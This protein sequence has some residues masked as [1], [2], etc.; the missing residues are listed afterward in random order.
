MSKLFRTVLL[1]LCLISWCLSP[2]AAQERPAGTKTPNYQMILVSTGKGWQLLRYKP[3]T[4]ETWSIQDM[5]WRKILD[6]E[7]LPAGDYHVQMV[8]LTAA[9]TWE[10]TRIER[11][12]GRSWIV[13]DSKWVEIKESK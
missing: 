3:A 13:R 7:K 12:S 5:A 2:I 6:T 10:A 1:G 4:G 8:G 11:G 9:E